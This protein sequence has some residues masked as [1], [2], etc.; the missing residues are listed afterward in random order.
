MCNVLQDISNFFYKVYEI[1]YKH[2]AKDIIEDIYETARFR[3]V[4]F[5]YKF[6]QPFLQAFCIKKI[7]RILATL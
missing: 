6:R 3:I 4:Y 1:S 2:L 5:L 7:N